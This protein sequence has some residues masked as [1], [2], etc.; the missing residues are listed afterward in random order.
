MKHIKSIGKCFAILY[1]VVFGC[2]VLIS[3]LMG[4]VLADKKTDD[5]KQKDETAKTSV[6]ESAKAGEKKSGTQGVKKGKSRPLKTSTV[7]KTVI[8]PHCSALRK[9]LKGDLNTKD[10]WAAVISEAEILSEASYI[11]MSDGRC[12]DEVWSGAATQTLRYC[13]HVIIAAAEEKNQVVV[14]TAFG[15]LT[16]SCSVC[17]DAHREKS[18]LLEL[19]E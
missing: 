15:K 17:H 19:V 8:R 10:D 18:P 14:R 5:T 7:M 1:I 4:N 13:A 16:E 12:P 3:V 11:L 6:K 2:M 9:I